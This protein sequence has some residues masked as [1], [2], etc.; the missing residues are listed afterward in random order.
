MAGSSRRFCINSWCLPGHHPLGSGSQ[1][2]L[3]VVVDLPLTSS[4]ARALDYR[5]PGYQQAVE[6]V[7][8]ALLLAGR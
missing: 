4:F 2:P 8:V 6:G 3:L 5:A 7:Q 1:E